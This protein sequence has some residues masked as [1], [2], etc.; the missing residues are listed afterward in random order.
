MCYTH[1]IDIPNPTLTLTLSLHN[2][3]VFIL[4]NIRHACNGKRLKTKNNKERE[5]RGLT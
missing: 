4:L 5:G 3:N 1:T 2:A